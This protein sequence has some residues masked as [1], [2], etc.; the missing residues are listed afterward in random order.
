MVYVENVEG[1]E[2]EVKVNLRR[3][4]QFQPVGVCA[5]KGA[6]EAIA[7]RLRRRT[8]LRASRKQIA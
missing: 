4:S 5:I 2:I 6:Q 1:V 8:I 3:R 7:G